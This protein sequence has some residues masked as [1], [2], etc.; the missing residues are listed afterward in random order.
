MSFPVT[1]W[2]SLGGLFSF[3]WREHSRYFLMVSAYLVLRKSNALEF[4]LIDLDVS[5]F[6][7]L[8]LDPGHQ[9]I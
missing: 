2:D 1:D 4:L 6:A 7:V 8:L 3:Y 5:H 9:Q